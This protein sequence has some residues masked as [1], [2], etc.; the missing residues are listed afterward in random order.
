MERGRKEGVGDSMRGGLEG[1]PLVELSREMV[2]W[3]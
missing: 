3:D 1:D 2:W